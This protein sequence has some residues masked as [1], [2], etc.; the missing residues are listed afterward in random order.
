MAPEIP[1]SMKDHRDDLL[2]MAESGCPLAELEAEI[3]LSGLREDER[4]ALWLWAWAM[5]SSMRRTSAS[6][7]RCRSA[8]LGS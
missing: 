8:L 3:H 4:D 6:M 5:P 7:Q 2:E 1:R